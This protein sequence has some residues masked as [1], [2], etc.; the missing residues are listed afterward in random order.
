MEKR[1]KALVVLYCVASSVML[2]TNKRA[3]ML[4]PA[5][6]FLLALQIISTVL[7]AIGTL[8]DVHKFATIALLARL[9]GFSW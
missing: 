6:N 1:T 8:S 5:P 7:L 4:I 3:V 2:V 9:L